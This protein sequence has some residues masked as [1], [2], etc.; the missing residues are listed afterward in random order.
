VHVKDIGE[1]LS[2]ARRGGPAGI[3]G[4]PRAIGDA[5]NAGNVRQCPRILA[6][7]GYRGVVT[8]ECS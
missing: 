2:A 4:S 8:I 5:V 1:R 7:C 3:A 6:E